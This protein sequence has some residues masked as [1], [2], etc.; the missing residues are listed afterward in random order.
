MSSL[1]LWTRSDAWRAQITQ[2]LGQRGHQVHA[3]EQADAVMQAILADVYRG[4]ILDH[5]ILTA[6]GGASILSMLSDAGF[7]GQV[8]ALSEADHPSG[9]IASMGDQ[10]G[11]SISEIVHMDAVPTAQQ[12]QGLVAYFEQ[13]PPSR[14]AGLTFDS[15]PGFQQIQARYKAKLPAQLQALRQAFDDRA[16]VDLQKQAH[17]IKGGAGSFGLD[18]L[19]ELAA[20]LD[21]AARG[22]DEAQAL[23][24]LASIEHEFGGE[25]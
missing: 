10:Q 16:W 18:R 9:S 19:T 1:L 11:V 22:Q 21:R 12:L 8:I 23:A 4:L 2:A 24:W 17:A 6:S 7:Q 20:E 5:A 15:L 13:R 14:W 3:C 25:V